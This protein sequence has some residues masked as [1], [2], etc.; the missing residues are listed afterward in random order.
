MVKKIPCRFILGFLFA[1]C[2]VLTGC[3]GPQF[4]CN[5][6]YDEEV[7]CKLGQTVEEL[8]EAFGLTHILEA[9]EPGEL[10]NATLT[11]NEEPLLSVYF[12]PGGEGHDYRRDPILQIRLHYLFGPS[13]GKSPFFSAGPIPLFSTTLEEVEALLGEPEDRTVSS[14]NGSQDLYY[15]D[16]QLWVCINEHGL[17][18]E[19]SIK[20]K[21]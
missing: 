15:C 10:T 18:D 17:V 11:M 3:G 6:I 7:P 20:P 9:Q 8:G 2:L 14:G 19:I 13:H 21:A 16:G 1:L 5:G 4:S 12:A